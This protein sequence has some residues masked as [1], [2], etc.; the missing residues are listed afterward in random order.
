[1]EI[2]VFNKNIQRIGTIYNWVSLLWCPCYNTIGTVTLEV[3][4]SSNYG[5]ILKAWNYLTLSDD[6]HVM[7]ITAVQIGKG[8]IVATGFTAEY[9]LSKRASTEIVSN[10]NGEAAIRRL[11]NSMVPWDNFE[12]GDLANITTTY[13]PQISDKQLTGYIENIAQECDFGF[14]T[15]RVGNKLKFVMYKPS[16]NV[17]A[18]FSNV[19]GN[20]SD[21]SYSFSANN[22]YNV[23]IVAGEDAELPKYLT[24][25]SNQ[26]CFIDTGIYPDDT[27]KIQITFVVRNSTGGCIVGN[28]TLDESDMFRFF[29]FNDHPHLDYGSGNGYNRLV[30]DDITL[31]Y[32]HEFNIEIGNRYIKDLSNNTY[33]IHDSQVSFAQKSYTICIGDEIIDM[34]FGRVKVWKGGNLISD[35]KPIKLSGGQLGM[36]DSV[37]NIYLDKSAQSTSDFTFV[38]G[39]SVMR[40]T[41]CAGDLDSTGTNRMELYL[42]ARNE[43][44]TENMSINDYVNN[45]RLYGEQ[46]LVEQ[47]NIESVQF[48][49]V[50]DSVSMGETVSIHMDT[51]NLQLLARVISLTIK[52]QNNITEK[53]IGV[54]TPVIIRRS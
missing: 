15:I 37:R 34:D 6:D 46:K 40:I 30:N 41:E 24:K 13:T 54:G 39:S 21:E 1:M 5:D 29:N 18:K 49:L 43:R 38:E 22:N 19:Y 3:Q 12:L 47:S 14:K 7:V 36:Y 51:P 10:E 42:D 4:Q 33:W 26:V 44:A 50:D 28:R 52:S 53:T 9:I 11:I 23:A 35:M 48:K 16:T 2:N 17:N 20:L 25:G 32:N 27:T 31:Q 8:K 45:L